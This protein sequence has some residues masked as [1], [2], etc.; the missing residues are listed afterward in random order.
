MLDSSSLCLNSYDL[1]LESEYTKIRQYLYSSA[2]PMS[3]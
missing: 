3:G 2:Q 1:R